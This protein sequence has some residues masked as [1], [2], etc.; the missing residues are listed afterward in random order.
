MEFNEKLQELR[1]NKNMTQEELAEA[2]FVSRTAISK[3]ESGRGYPNIDSLKDISN[4]FGVTIDELLSA[5]RI[6]SI[7]QR[8]NGSNLRRISDLLFGMVDLMTIFLVILPLYPKPVDGYIYSTGLLS[9]HEVS[10]FNM[11]VYWS[12]YSLLILLGIAKLLLSCLKI[13][14]PQK[15]IT[16]ISIAC[17]AFGV[18]FLGAAKEPYALMVL[19]LLLLVK[20]VLFF[21]SIFGQRYT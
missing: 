14:K 20:L 12:L 11:I 6:I 2:L 8:E 3:W 16:Y 13:E 9:Y 1:R 5:E 19:F 15:P 17:A 18:L 10:A 4:F 21:K 7:A